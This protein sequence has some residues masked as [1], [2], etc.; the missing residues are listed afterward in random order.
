[1]AIN[2]AKG[3]I[4]N[5]LTSV[6]DNHVVAVAS[7]I[8]DENL[9][10][11]QSEI[12]S[13]MTQDQSE[14]AY[15]TSGTGQNSTVLKGGYNQAEG[16]YSVA[17]GFKSSAN[18][19][20]SVALG[21]GL[22]T[23]NVA[24]AAVGLYNT[25]TNDGTESGQTI[26]NVG[27][28][29]ADSERRNGF[30]VR[31]NGD[32]YYWTNPGANDGTNAYIR[33][34]S[35]IPNSISDLENDANYITS[36]VTDLANFYNKSQTYD[37]ETINEMIGSGLGLDIVIVETLPASGEP[38][39]IYLV[40]ASGDTDNY[41]E[42]LYAK[43]EEDVYSWVSV[44]TMSADMSAYYTKTAVDTKISDLVVSATGDSTELTISQQKITE[45]ING[46][47]NQFD[48]QKVSMGLSLSKSVGFKYTSEYIKPTLY[49]NG[50]FAATH[51]A[52]YLG[53]SS[54]GTLVAEGEDLVSL[55]W[56][57]DTSGFTGNTSFY[58]VATI[59]G[60]T[61]S[62][63]ATYRA[64]G[65]VYT[66]FF[67]DLTT[68]EGASVDSNN[69]KTD[70]PVTSSIVG[71]TFNASPK[72]GQAGQH[73]YIFVGEGVTGASRFTMNA[74]PFEMN[75]YAGVSLQGQQGTFT[76]YESKS[77]FSYGADVSVKCE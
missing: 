42:W 75:T 74:T 65:H 63:T 37:R 51:A 68:A 76:V 46:L 12:N 2:I 58:G 57:N 5:A 38:S 17:A 7:D 27:I 43:N 61:F 59:K 23:G 9:G 25:S 55:T 73:F 15:W 30:E 48:L 8:Y 53:S 35:T 56:D 69:F 60:K 3:K 62:S 6:A 34:Q 10:K 52:L 29:S 22:K 64:Y 13:G 49:V 4:G 20:F 16:D 31:R 72:A 21:E 28:G 26:F 70:I 1:M 45:L 18:T 54:A 71:T 41:T 40:K 33:L 77:V 11:Y 36:G 67:S 32:I 47:Q 39:T 50:G 19:D 14:G 44:G 66:A 24:E